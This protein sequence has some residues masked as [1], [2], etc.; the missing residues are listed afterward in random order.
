LWVA[1]DRHQFEQDKL[2][3]A[4]ATICRIGPG[5]RV[6]FQ[7]RA[8]QGTKFGL[9]FKRKDDPSGLPYL[10][11]AVITERSDRSNLAVGL[12]HNSSVVEYGNG[13]AALSQLR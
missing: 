11:L 5:V 3:Q 9:G 12:E 8:A 4:N 10:A 7:A 13:H 6:N 1:P 2:Q